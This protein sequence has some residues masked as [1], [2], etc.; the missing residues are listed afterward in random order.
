MNEELE[1]VAKVEVDTIE[2][3][4]AAVGKVTFRLNNKGEYIITMTV[5]S[6]DLSKNAIGDLAELCTL[7][8]GVLVSMSDRNYT[9]ELM[10]LEEE[11]YK[12]ELV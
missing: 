10:D 11:G 6:N 7:P 2:T 4:F 9:Q 1:P 8:N 5:D 12:T 3:I